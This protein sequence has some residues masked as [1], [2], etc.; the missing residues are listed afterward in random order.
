LLVAVYIDMTTLGGESVGLIMQSD[1][2]FYAAKDIERNIPVVGSQVIEE[3]A[4]N[5]TT[6]GN[7]L[8]NS[9]S[10][11]KNQLQIKMN[12]ITQNMKTSIGA[13]DVSCN[14]TS[15]ESSSNPLLL[16]VNSTIY[17]KK[18][19][20]VHK[21]TLSQDIDLEG[22]PDP[23]PFI[24][25]KD[26]GITPLPILDNSSGKISYGTSL[27]QY[28]Q[29]RGVANYTIY[30]NATSQGYLDRCSFEPYDS[31]TDG[32]GVNATPPIQNLGY[33]LSNGYYHE[34]SDG[35][36]YLCRLEG[37][38]VCSH[39]G[40]ETFIVPPLSNSATLTFAPVSID[41]V[42]FSDS[43]YSGKALIYDQDT[44]NNRYYKLY[45]DNGHR[46]KYGL[47]NY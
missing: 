1:T 27:S 16:E 35:A 30:E 24:K 15:I 29:K 17:I 3:V 19:T 6:T 46:S 5:V 9:R 18:G 2:T 23:I 4:L 25:I 41:H 39:Y 11:I 36:C 43:P 47:V 21:D 37:K 42:I 45:L 44:K 34:S 14:I 8:D 32:H 7:K 10:Y 31:S 13:D 40:I 12:D 26:E 33:C 20:S 38:A 28:L 22:L